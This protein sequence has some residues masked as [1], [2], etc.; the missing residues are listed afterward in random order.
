MDPGHL[1]H[2][3]SGE[4]PATSGS[5]PASSYADIVL[6]PGQTFEGYVVVDVLGRGGA[7]TVL[8]AHAV[9]DPREVVALKVLADDHRGPA[10]STRLQREFEFAQ[11]LY[12]PHVVS[13][14]RRGDDWLSMQLVDGG[15]GTAL[16]DLDDRLT[17]IA[18]IADAL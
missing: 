10:E 9:G 11:Q 2:S 4:I 5:K 18:Q 13:V 12:H 17:A 7:A 16:Q 3:V 6:R 1:H 8:R 15:T 14:Y